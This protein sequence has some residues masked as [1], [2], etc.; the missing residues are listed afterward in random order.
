M[1]FAM[2]KDTLA[3]A[4][5]DDPAC[6]A[7]LL[8]SHIFGVSPAMQLA[9]PEKDYESQAL[10][11]ALARRSAREPL[12]HILGEAYFCGERFTV[13]ADCLIPRA[14]T[15]LLVEQAAQLLP[16][17]A[18]FADLC[19][20]SGCIAI[21]LLCLR[22]DLSA[23]AAD[24]SPA[25]LAVAKE[26]AEALGVSDRIRFCKADLLGDT[27][28]FPM[29]DYLLSNPP[30]I[31]EDVLSTLAPELGF[32]PRIAL[33]GGEDGLI[34]YRSFLARF[35]PA[36]FLF[37]IGFDQGEAVSALGEAAGYRACVR[38]DLGGR[39]RVVILTKA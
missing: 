9:F 31:K 23:I 36:C 17:G 30:Y 34:F 1:T 26:N 21:A 2:I 29:P 12:Q 15:E 24:I 4:G 33:D 38:K 3:K 39:D 5:V 13:S 27:L 22:P 35:H 14:D 19:T 32:E 11:D 18:L 37:E 16:H 6:D 20:G 7:R 10:T 8:I 25:A 28:P